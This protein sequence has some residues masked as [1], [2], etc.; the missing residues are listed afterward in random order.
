[1]RGLWQL[2]ALATSPLLGGTCL[3]IDQHRGSRNFAQLQLN[4]IELITMK[5]VHTGL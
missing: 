5:D 1:M 4:G 2:T 3:V